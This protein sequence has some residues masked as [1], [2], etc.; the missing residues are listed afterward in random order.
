KLFRYAEVARAQL[1]N[2][3]AYQGWIA[4]NTKVA[5]P[6]REQYLV[7]VHELGHVLGLPHNP[8]SRSVMYYLRLDG[9][10]VLASADLAALAVRH[11][12]RRPATRYAVTVTFQGRTAEESVAVQESVDSS[13]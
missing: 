7:A 1:P 13:P 11:K 4:F 3:A 5:L 9:Q 12:T 2:R 8:N 10:T 6:K